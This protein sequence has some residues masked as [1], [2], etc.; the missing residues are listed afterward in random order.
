MSQQ[1][2][3]A[4]RIFA[5]QD[6][7]TT[8]FQDLA[9]E[10]DVS[11][12]T[13]YNYFR[14]REEL[15]E[16]VGIY[17]ASEL[18]EAI[19]QLSVGVTS[20]AQRLAI[21]VRMFVLRAQADLQWAN[22]L[23]RLIHFDRAMH[24]QLTQHVLEDLRAGAEEG[25]FQYEDEDIALDVVISCATGAIRAVMEGRAVGEHDVRVTEM[26]LRALGATPAKAK[27]IAAM[28]LP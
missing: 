23:A 25:V 1:L 26:V 19:T 2:D 10:A 5:R 22:A 11:T 13:I 6:V 7:A 3:T 24:V 18:S 12:G 20:G 21:G 9:T 28:P 14:T 4:F 27:K 8:V 16:A 15:A 17:L